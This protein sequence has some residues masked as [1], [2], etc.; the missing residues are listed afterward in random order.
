V[1]ELFGLS[2]TYI[3]IALLV[4]MSM[5]AATIGWIIARNRVMFFVGVRNIP[6]RRAQTV[7]IIVGLML[8]TL[9]ISTAFSI[10]DTVDYSITNQVYDRMHSIDEVVQAQSA[11]ETGSFDASAI[12]SAKPIPEGQASQYVDAFQTIPGVKGAVSVIRGPVPVKDA[13]SG[14]SE[15]LVVLVGLDATHMQG[16]ESDIT[17]V[18][19]RQ[20]SISA[21][22]ADDVYANA[23]AADKLDIVKGD[24][25]QVF[26][27]GQPHFL[28]VRE[29]VV[30]RV[31]T[32][33]VLGTPRGL[34]T[35]LAR[36]Q[37]LFNRAGEVDM[38]AVSNSGGVRGTLNASTGI[39]AALNDR[40]QGTSWRAVAAKADAVNEASTVASVFTTLFVV[41]GLFSIAAGM[42]LIFLI[43]V[44]LAAERKVE[45]GMMRAVG[46]KRSH[47]VQAFM[48]EGMAYNIGAAAVGCALGIA[49][50]L[51]MVQVMAALFS[52]FD[53]SIVFHVTARSLIV[54][55]AL[56]VVLTFITV[57]FSAW[58]IGSLNIVSAI[59]DAA[60][61]MPPRT[62]PEWR[63]GVG[64]V[65]RYAK[66]LVFK[67]TRLVEW[68]AGLGFLIL[69]PALGFVCGV[70]FM[71]S[72]GIYGSSGVASVIA[73]LLATAAIGVGTLA[74]VA[75]GIGLNRIFQMGT[76]SMVVGALLIVVA[77]ATN[78]ASPYGIGLTLVLLGTALSLVMLR[79]PPRP[80]FTTM[81][82]L[83]LGYWTLGAGGH[84]PPH[85]LE[86]GSD[87][88]FVSGFIMVMAGTFI[89]VYNADLMLAVLTR[90]GSNFSH[91]VP[92]I[93]TAVAYPMAN[94]FRTGMTIAM[95]S[96]VMFALVMMTTMN[97]NFGR[98]FLSSDALGG[99]DIV[100]SENPSNPIPDMT[101]ALRAAGQDTSAI[102][103][104]DDIRLANRRIAEVRMAPA[105][106][107]KGND[108]S[109]YGVGGPALE[110]TEGNA[111]KFQARA[112]GFATDADVWRALREQPDTAVID[113]FALPSG[114]FG[115]PG[116]F[117]LEG[118]KAN[119]TSINPIPI[120]VRDSSDASNVRTLRIIGIFS[121]KASAVY[122]GLFLSPAAFDSVFPH[123]E[124]TMHLLKLKPGTDSVA[125]AKSIEK[126]L[127]AQGVQANSLRKLIDDQQA[128]SQGFLYLIDGFMGIG[129]FVGIA[130]VG[131][132][133][134]RTVV[135]R[136]QQIG[137]LRAIGFTR[138][139]VATSFIMESSF[140]TLLGVLSG[141]GL[142]LLLA[143]QL[144]TSKDF[145][146][147]ASV[148]FYVPWLEISGIGTFAFVA[149]LIMTIIP[150]RQA[151]SIPIAEAL[152]YE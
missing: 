128:Q 32:G 53:L 23:S 144:V 66:W 52:A 54:S 69:V 22:G 127:T 90:L 124:S 133:A 51:L 26:T 30:D 68:A 39:K 58:R 71:G 87:L 73:V 138:G 103:R 151:S 108:F 134:F 83:V 14:L 8:S 97:S 100:V 65:L 131:V 60:D 29:I 3:M 85:R 135:E 82:V 78:Q 11:T 101:S 40:L 77:F 79:I 88:F 149:S 111:I 81:G 12:I 20:V 132:I 126:T 42:M 57:T 104:E 125:E 21:L 109:K 28:T 37:Q 43:F 89:L 45:M 76:L 93:R 63:G 120:E 33:T 19:G 102:T 31:L 146:P 10:G 35:S 99:Y 38:I 150:A 136:R 114:G 67:P 96:L 36:A 117:T 2:M 147:G 59:R 9:I 44:M 95:I 107:E 49:V 130:A 75:A 112:E 55:Y 94:K 5:A 64:S 92:A 123:P 4:I 56:G 6:R 145:A 16:F 119:V 139:A 115:P 15:P 25:I 17:T 72:V 46:T 105:A 140:I 110:F 27:G 62:R 70:M 18:D 34:V 137:M 121:L 142:G 141:I 84:L 50:S 129:L 116:G 118:V 80:A 41:L 113:A 143:E 7:L 13:R 74:V 152:R 24:Q 148:S 61:P 122:N 91:L 106:S 86:G 47:L 1:N 98:M 48:S